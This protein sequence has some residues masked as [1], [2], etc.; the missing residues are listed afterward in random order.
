VYHIL[1]YSASFIPYSAGNMSEKKRKYTGKTTV[2]KLDVITEV[3]ENERSKSEI[4]QVYGIPL[5]TM[6]MY[7]KNKDSVEQQAMQRGSILKYS[8]I[9]GAKLGDLE[10]ELFKWFCHA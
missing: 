3:D 9:H 5:S 10:N 6:L 1:L 4:A 2:E 7:L 8:R